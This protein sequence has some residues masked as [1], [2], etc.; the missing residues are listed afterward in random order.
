MDNIII[1]S[2]VIANNI[3]VI[4]IVLYFEFIKH[5]F[6]LLLLISTL[7]LLISRC[8]CYW[9]QHCPNPTTI[10]NINFTTVALTTTTTSTS[11]IN[12]NLTMNLGTTYLSIDKDHFSS[13][14]NSLDTS[15]HS[16]TSKRCPAW[17]TELRLFW[18]DP[19]FIEINLNVRVFLIR[20]MK[21][22]LWIPVQA[23][24]DFL[25]QGQVLEYATYV[26]WR[27]WLRNIIII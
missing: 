11:I 16:P 15:G 27:S 18:N 23:V 25:K 17:P 14:H 26:T 19:L 13:K 7:L 8:C 24:D 21:D 22:T 2:F 4:I 9:Y 3:V 1:A 6:M 5:C 10:I 20:K 12:N